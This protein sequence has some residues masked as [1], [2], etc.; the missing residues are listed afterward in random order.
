MVIFTDLDGTLLDHEN[1]SFRMALPALDLLR[2]RGVPVVPVSSKTAP[3]VRLWMGYLQLEGPFIYENGG[4]IIIPGSYFPFPLEGFDPLGREM[5]LSLGTGVE[6][7]RAN[8]SDIALELALEIQGFGGMAPQEVTDLTGLK[9]PELAMSLEREF[10]EPFRVVGQHNPEAL[11]ESAA[12]RGL[13]LIRGGRL[14]HL[15]GGCDKGKAVT[16]VADLFRKVNPDIITVGVG[17]AQNDWSFL[18]VVDR[19]FL[20]QRSDGTFDPTVPEGEVEHVR[21]IGPKGWRM[22]IEGLFATGIVKGNV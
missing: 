2:R 11:V 9:G 5:K 21:G 12:R 10:D 17:D 4:G 18:E 3:E 6:E 22:A 20:V 7:V 16:I 8:L 19:P 14:Y 1:Y 15:T 13:N